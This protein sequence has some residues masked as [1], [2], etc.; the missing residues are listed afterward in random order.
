MNDKYWL[1]VG[2]LNALTLCRV[3]KRQIAIEVHDVG[4]ACLFLDECLIA[5]LHVG[6]LTDGG[7]PPAVDCSQS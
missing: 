7:D 3:R 2:C 4:F 1:I 5:E 6:E